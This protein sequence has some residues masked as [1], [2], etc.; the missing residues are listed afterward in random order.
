[1]GYITTDICF[2]V[3]YCA[4]T[5]AYKWHRVERSIANS[6]NCAKQRHYLFL[7]QHGNQ[8]HVSFRSV[9]CVSNRMNEF[10]IG[11]LFLTKTHDGFK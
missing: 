9:S 3:Y 5:A 10:R 7:R 2:E 6:V 8:A 11:L 1:M 4:I